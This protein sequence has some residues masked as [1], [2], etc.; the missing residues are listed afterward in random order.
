MRK[1][2]HLCMMKKSQKENNSQDTRQIQAR[3]SDK[4]VRKDRNTCSEDQCFI[5]TM[6]LSL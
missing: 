3:E 5:A 1:N 6:I 4:V 2:V